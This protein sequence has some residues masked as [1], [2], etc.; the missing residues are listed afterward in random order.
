M[1]DAVK[2][3]RGS[4]TLL[5]IHADAPDVIVGV[6]RNSPL[7]VGLGD[8]ENFM[9]S[10][11]AA[12]IEFTKKAIELGQ[13]EIVTMTPTSVEITDLDGKSVKPKHY[14]ISWHLMSP[15]LSITP[16][17]QWN[18]AKMKLSRSAQRQSQSVTSKVAQSHF[19]NMK[20]HGM[21]RLRRR[22][23]LHTSCSKRSLINL[24]RL[25]TL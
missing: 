18:L 4:F 24:R 2:A 10:D 5:A 1:R 7:V 19:V 16:S 6:R 9:A 20:S 22:V 15:H 14:E 8:G 13:D 12:F 23:A 17:A 3:L 25:P 21:Q 11:V